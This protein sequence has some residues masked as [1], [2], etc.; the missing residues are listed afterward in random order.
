MHFTKFVKKSDMRKNGRI[1]DKMTLKETSFLAASMSHLYHE[2][3]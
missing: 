1:K 3:V 2:Y